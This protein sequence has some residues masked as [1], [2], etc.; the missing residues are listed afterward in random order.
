[1][2]DERVPLKNFVPEEFSK[3]TDREEFVSLLSQFLMQ[4]HN[5]TEVRALEIAEDAANFKYGRTK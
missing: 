1:M 2:F 5:F 4:K 3:I